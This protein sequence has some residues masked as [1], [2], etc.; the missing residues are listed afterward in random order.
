MS[1]KTLHVIKSFLQIQRRFE[2]EKINRKMLSIEVKTFY[3][4]QLNAR[5]SRIGY[6][7]TFISIVEEYIEDYL[8]RNFKLFLSWPHVNN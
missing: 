8:E 7:P 3:V 4:Y 6:Q 1:A 2:T 5:V